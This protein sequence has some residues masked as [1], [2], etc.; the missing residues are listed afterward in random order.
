MIA[1]K[2]AKMYLKSI[3]RDMRY[4][5]RTRGQA[6]AWFLYLN[7]ETPEEKELAR[8]SV[9]GSNGGRFTDKEAEGL[10]TKIPATNIEKDAMQ[11]IDDL[12][13]NVGLGGSNATNV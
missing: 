5:P 7:A 8:I 10:S 12:L 4:H 11:G 2:A 3:M 9:K 1:A 6:L 13:D